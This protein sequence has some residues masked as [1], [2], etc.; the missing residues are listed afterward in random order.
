MV[1]KIV[2][3]N[4]KKMAKFVVKADDTVLKLVAYDNS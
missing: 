1:Q 3:L 4:G 2:E